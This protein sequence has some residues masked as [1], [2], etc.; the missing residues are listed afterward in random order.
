MCA[1]QARDIGQFTHIAANSRH[2]MFEVKAL[3]II[4][5]FTKLLSDIDR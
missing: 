3:K 1:L 5:R 4:A 2:M